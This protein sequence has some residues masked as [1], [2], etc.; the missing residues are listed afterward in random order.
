MRQK[1]YLI[2][3]VVYIQMPGSKYICANNHTH[4]LPNSFFSLLAEQKHCS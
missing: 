3:V 4:F 2:Q 1:N